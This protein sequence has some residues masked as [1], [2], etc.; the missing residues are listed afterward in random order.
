MGDVALEK[1][2]LGVDPGVIEVGDA[3]EGQYGD[4]AVAGLVNSP[5]EVVE[6]P[7]GSGGAGGGDQQRIVDCRIVG[8]AAAAL[9]VVGIF[10]RD[11]AAGEAEAALAQNLDG[12][13]AV[14]VAGVAEGGR[15]GDA[16]LG[17]AG[18]DMIDVDAQFVVRLGRD[19]LMV[20]S[21]VADFEAVGVERGDFL[22]GHIALLVDQKAQTFG[23]VEGG[24][25]A[26][27]FEQRRGEGKLRFWPVVEGQGDQAVGKGTHLSAPRRGPRGRVYGG[28][29]LRG[30]RLVRRPSPDRR[31]GADSP[32]S[33]AGF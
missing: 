24:V 32:R 2:G 9:V 27:F 25:E 33:R 11:A 23:D 5:E 13:R 4:L 29:G 17:T 26:A 31:A 12:L 18:V 30:R 28:S 7:L 8:R 6:A 22:P 1:V 3:V 20:L 10:G 14:A 19:I 21:V 15:V 16:V